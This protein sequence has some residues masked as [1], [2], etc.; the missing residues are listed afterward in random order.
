MVEWLNRNSLFKLTY[1][2]I[3]VFLVKFYVE[4]KNIEKELLDS[5]SLIAVKEKEDKKKQDVIF[6]EI[7]KTLG[8]LSDQMN[9]NKDNLKQYSELAKTLGKYNSDLAS[10][11]KNPLGNINAKPSAKYIDNTLLVSS[12]DDA[13]AIFDLGKN[14]EPN[15]VYS[16]IQCRKSRDVF[17][18]ATLCVHDIHRDIHVSGS[19]WRDGIWELHIIQPFMQIINN[20]PDWLVLGMLKN[21]I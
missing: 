21:K 8:E 12:N 16:P 9:M 17:V 19:I 7:K 2:I 18:S 11:I 6:Y 15:D 14:L 10:L 3:I 1:L 20:N 4:K 13:V 5:K